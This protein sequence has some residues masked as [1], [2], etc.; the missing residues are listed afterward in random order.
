MDEMTLNIFSLSIII[1]KRAVNLEKEI[2]REK[3]EKLYQHY[4]DQAHSMGHWL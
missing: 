1:K 3:V 4:K 2:H